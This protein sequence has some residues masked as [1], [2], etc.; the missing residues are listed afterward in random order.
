MKTFS[1][2]RIGLIPRPEGVGGVATFREKFERAL[3]AR[4]LEVEYDLRRP[5]D[6]VL[7]LAGT[8]RLQELWRLRRQGVRLVQRLDGINWVHRRTCTGWR[9]FLRSEYGNFILA[10]IRNRLAH[11]IIYQSRFSQR[12]W[13]EWYG[14]AEAPSWIVYN[15]VDT[16]L[17]TPQG[18]HERPTDRWRILIVEGS[19]GGGYEMGLW[20]AIGLLR[21]LQAQGLNVELQV[22]G[23][24]SRKLQKQVEASVKHGLRW[25]GVVPRAQ[26]PYLARSAHLFFSGDINAACPNSVIEALACGLPV[27]AFDTGAL[28]ELVV[29]EAG[30]LVPYGGDPWKL[31]PPNIAG[32][33]PAAQEILSRQEHF[34]NAA[35]AHAESALNIEKMVEGYLKVLLE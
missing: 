25:A 7:I 11:R 34:R 28:S 17:Y 19:F 30:R 15:G 21:G 33:L 8:H 22:A 20:N 18:A 6:A 23:Q 5:V 12:W 3:Q 9:H 29:G 10:T 26:I 13:E 14:P 31:S 35:R 32:L 16:R 24:V 2:A 4:G 27:L 1:S